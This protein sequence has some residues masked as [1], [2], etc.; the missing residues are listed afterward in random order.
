MAQKKTL[1]IIDD[2]PN[3]R[4]LLSHFLGNYYTIIEKAG[5]K[6]ALESL[7]EGLNADLIISDILMPDMS[8]IEFLTVY[9]KQSHLKSTPVIVLSSVE[10]SAERLKCFKYGARDFVIKP[11]NPE[12]LHVRI[13][14]LLAA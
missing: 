5:A 11:F 4:L 10:N 13:K 8:G 12:E 6:E 9:Q 2:Q 7:N 1:M 3:T 14:N